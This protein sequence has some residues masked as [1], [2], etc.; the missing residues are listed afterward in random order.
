MSEIKSAMKHLETSPLSRTIEEIRDVSNQYFSR[1]NEMRLECPNFTVFNTDIEN[2]MRLIG[3]NVDY[4]KKIKR[5]VVIMTGPNDSS[6]IAYVF[7]MMS[8]LSIYR[9]KI[10]YHF[11]EFFRECTKKGFVYYRS[12][13][14]HDFF[15]AIG[16]HKDTL[17]DTE[18][19]YA[20]FVD[21]VVSDITSI[22][23]KD[24]SRISII[25]NENRMIE[26]NIYN[27]LLTAFRVRNDQGLFTDNM[28]NEMI[29]MIK[30][31]NDR[32]LS[33]VYKLMS[34]HFKE[35]ILLVNSQPIVPVN[36]SL[37][38]W[39]DPIHSRNLR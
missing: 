21:R 4:F 24:A 20:S 17:L 7:L 1:I 36:T 12:N 31:R 2:P 18:K 3:K 28:R 37:V 13:V 34:L 5:F 39:H 29:G 25:L 38:D 32:C 35:I 11:G 23:D 8:V 15:G 6:M 9:H 10:S 16:N 26:L 19:Y 14:D 27:E 30:R 33:L 22:L